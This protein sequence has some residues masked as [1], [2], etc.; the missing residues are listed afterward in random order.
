MT[1]EGE[2]AKEMVKVKSVALERQRGGVSHIKEIGAPKTKAKGPRFGY[3][4]SCVA[5]AILVFIA[6]GIKGL[7]ALCVVSVA[8][9]IL[10]I[11]ANRNRVETPETASAEILEELP[12]KNQ[13]AHDDTD[14][15]STSSQQYWFFWDE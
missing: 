12:I 11:L 4:A 1:M 14:S 6:M 15:L 7:A 10:D 5:I 2:Q 9:Y 3:I 13:S 8:I